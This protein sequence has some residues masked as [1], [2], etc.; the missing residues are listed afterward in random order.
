MVS[1][2]SPDGVETDILYD[3]GQRCEEHLESCMD[4]AFLDLKE[5]GVSPAHQPFCGCTT[6]IVREVLMVAWP[7]FLEHFGG[8]DSG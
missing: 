5:T 1:P 4:A 6:C 3:I 8:R 7:L 2:T